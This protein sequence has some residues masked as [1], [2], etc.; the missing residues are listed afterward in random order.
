[1]TD[2]P[3]KMYELK[4]TDADIFSENLNRELT[5]DERYEVRVWAGVVQ[6][7]CHLCACGTEI[8]Y[9]CVKDVIVH[10]SGCDRVH[11]G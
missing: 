2:E 4:G 5:E 1:M 6:M 3:Q 10:C 8:H 7:T 9:N 11:S